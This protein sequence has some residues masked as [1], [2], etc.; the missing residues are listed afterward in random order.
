MFTYAALRNVHLPTVSIFRAP[1]ASCGKQCPQARFVL[2]IITRDP[3]RVPCLTDKYWAS[4]PINGIFLARTLRF[5][6]ANKSAKP[7]PHISQ[8]SHEQQLRIED[9][10]VAACLKYAHKH[11]GM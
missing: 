4:F 3:L 11:L 8:L 5:I 7:L 6:Q 9:Q 1:L 10:N 2:E